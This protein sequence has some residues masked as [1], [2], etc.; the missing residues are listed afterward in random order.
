M[1][2]QGGGQRYNG[3]ILRW[4][5]LGGII[6]L[7]V[8]GRVDKGIYNLFHTW[9][10]LLTLCYMY[11][12]LVQFQFSHYHRYATECVCLCAWYTSL[13]TVVPLFAL[14]SHTASPAITTKSTSLSRYHCVHGIW[15]VHLYLAIYSLTSTSH[16]PQS[17]VTTS[18][19]S[20]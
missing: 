19:H 12:Y 6:G 16:A 3:D 17:L 18:D 7:I 14:P 2:S 8:R 20:G 10:T 9:V 4:S 13:I 5:N 11:K 1:N 15:L